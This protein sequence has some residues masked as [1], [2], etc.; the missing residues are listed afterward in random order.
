[1]LTR[2]TPSKESDVH[3]PQ[4]VGF[5]S[6]MVTLGLN[7]LVTEVTPGSLPGSPTS[8]STGVPEGDDQGGGG[9]EVSEQ[10]PR[11]KDRNGGL[12]R[13]RSGSP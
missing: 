2:K 1:M 11:P 13:R 12:S 3:T 4:S 7:R 9:K 10:D 8:G 5:T 6:G